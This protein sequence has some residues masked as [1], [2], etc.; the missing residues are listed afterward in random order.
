MDNTL[1]VT[2]WAE[3]VLIIKSVSQISLAFYHIKSDFIFQLNVNSLP[4]T[5]S[6]LNVIIIVR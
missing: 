5:T 6:V 2:L 4:L 3:P 1:P